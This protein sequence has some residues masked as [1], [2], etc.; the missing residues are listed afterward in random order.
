MDIQY[1]PGFLLLKILEKSKTKIP[2]FA[3]DYLD[4]GCNEEINLRKILTKSGQWNDT[5]IPC[6]SFRF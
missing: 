1:D 5:T 3:F 6:R 4:G 2:G